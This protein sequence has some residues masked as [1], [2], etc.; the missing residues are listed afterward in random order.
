MCQHE[1]QRNLR[2]RGRWQNNA[3]QQQPGPTKTSLSFPR[4][5][6]SPPPAP[7]H[8]STRAGA[9]LLPPL[10]HTDRACLA[11]SGFRV[12]PTP[13]SLSR[14]GDRVPPGS[15]LHGRRYHGRQRGQVGR[16]CDRVAWPRI[17]FP[18]AGRGERDAGAT[19]PLAASRRA[20]CRGALSAWHPCL[21]H[22]AALVAPIDAA[23]RWLSRNGGRAVRPSS[24]GEG[25]R[26]GHTAPL[27]CLRV[28][29]TPTPPHPH[30]T[31]TSRPGS[32]GFA[33]S[34]ATNFFAR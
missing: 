10:A 27:P 8:S 3:Q 15:A 25:K 30:T 9:R 7:T 24:V 19:P 21:C 11:A 28:P 32:R 16:E 5:T 31:A 2:K 13:L 4:G 18:E 6:H 26:K 23:A 20:L 12:P 17:R 22:P 1:S 34:R 29:R 14:N 33:R